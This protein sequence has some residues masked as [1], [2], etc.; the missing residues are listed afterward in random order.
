[1]AG[2]PAHPKLDGGVPA[3]RDHSDTEAGE[4]DAHADVRD[5]V[6]VYLSALKLELA[7]PAGQKAGEPDQHLSERWMDV[8]VELA[9]DVV[10]AELAE[11]GLVPDDV[12]RMTDAVEARPAR[13]E[14]VDRGRDVLRL[15]LEELALARRGVALAF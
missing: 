5:V 15:L 14:R 7:V 1:M 6:G 13:E 4:E 12:V 10:P 9:L 11:V 3:E 2:A 8:E